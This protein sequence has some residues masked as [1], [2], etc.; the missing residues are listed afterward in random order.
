MSIPSPSRYWL[1]PVLWFALVAAVGCGPSN[2]KPQ[3]PE[4]ESFIREWR[5]LDAEIECR[6]TL[7][8]DQIPPSEVPYETVEACV[9]GELQKGATLAPASVREGVQRGRLE[10]DSRAARQCLEQ[11]RS[12]AERSDACKALKFVRP[13]CLE[14]LT[15]TVP[16]G[17]PCELGMLECVEGS[18]CQ[19]VD[20]KCYGRCNSITRA[21]DGKSCDDGDRTESCAFSQNLICATEGGDS[22][23]HVCAKVDSR[24]K[25]EPC[26]DDLVCQRGLACSD[27]TCQTFSVVGE[28]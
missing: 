11:L 6:A 17:E 25:G 15:G 3:P 26:E 14:A 5:Q 1:P 20:G 24:A 19:R 28:G 16:E 7:K 23:G 12:D 13:T 9:R 21:G 10:Y 22:D 27:G 8:C 4:V 2:G 18:V